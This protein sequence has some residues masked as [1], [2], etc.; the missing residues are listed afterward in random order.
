M[1]R[2]IL[3][4]KQVA[5]RYG[6]STSWLYDRIKNSDESV[7]RPFAPGSWDS[8]DVDIALEQ[9][10]EKLKAASARCEGFSRS[11]GEVSA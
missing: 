6:R 2:S 3:R 10:I 7:P 1:S 9:H 8:V 11:Q 5:A 4:A